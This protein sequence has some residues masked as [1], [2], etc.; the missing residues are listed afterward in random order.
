MPA[1]ARPVGSI[2]V[3]LRSVLG[4]AKDPALLIE[5]LKEL[6]Q[7]SLDAAAALGVPAKD[8]QRAVYQAVKDSKRRRPSLVTLQTNRGF[9]AIL[10]HWRNDKRFRQANGEPRVLSITGRGVTLESLAKRYVP[11]LALREVTNMI[12]DNAEVRRVSDGK[13][14]LVGAAVMMTPKTPEQTLASLISRTRRITETILH[15]ATLPPRRID[16]GRFERVVSGELTDRQFEA[17]AQS[18]RHQLQNLCDQVDERIGQ[19]VRKS[20]R[21][22]VTQCGLGIYLFKDGRKLR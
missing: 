14:A 6:N 12:C 3:R 1:R 19:P 4:R 2:R 8:R 15:D 13:V 18:I 16:S 22:R 17:F 9:S 5:L 21:R 11:G 10:Y 7:I 20:K